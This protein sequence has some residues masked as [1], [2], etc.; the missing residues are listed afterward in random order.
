[1]MVKVIIKYIGPR[2]NAIVDFFVTKDKFR[3]V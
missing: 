1:M 3:K 2:Y